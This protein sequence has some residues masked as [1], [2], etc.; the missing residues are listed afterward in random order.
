ML[1][2]Q[3]V[4]D[5]ARSIMSQKARRSL[6]RSSHRLPHAPR[7]SAPTQPQLVHSLPLQIPL[8]PLFLFLPPHHPCLLPLLRLSHHQPSGPI[9]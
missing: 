1:H 5:M 3:P 8:P 2:F 6:H 9:H 4:R 7:P